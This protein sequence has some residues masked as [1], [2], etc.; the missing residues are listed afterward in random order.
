VQ[1]A[2]ERLRLCVATLLEARSRDVDGELVELD[3][4]GDPIAVEIRSGSHLHR[5]RPEPTGFMAKQ[6]LVQRS[7][8]AHLAAR[9]RH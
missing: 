5:H 6:R 7:D 9:A 4:L 1:L 8:R 2:S 3:H